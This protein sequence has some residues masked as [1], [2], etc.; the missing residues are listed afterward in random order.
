M[1]CPENPASAVKPIIS[2]D[3]PMA[4]RIGTF[5]TSTIAGSLKMP[6]ATPIIPAMNPAP[7][8]TGIR[9]G[10]RTV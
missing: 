1:R 7:A 6:P 2:A 8:V 10:R 9:P 4:M 5:P 3:V